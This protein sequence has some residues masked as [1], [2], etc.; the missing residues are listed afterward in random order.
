M[1][2]EELPARLAIIGGGY[3]GLEFSSYFA[4]F[5]AQVTVIQDGADFIPPRGP[6]GGRRRAAKPDG[7]RGSR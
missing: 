6:R 1:E 4:N 5:G 2:R 3:I 7:A